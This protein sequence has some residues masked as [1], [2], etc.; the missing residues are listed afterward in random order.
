[1]QLLGCAHHWLHWALQVL[2]GSPTSRH[3]PADLAA[4]LVGQLLQQVVLGCCCC[5][6]QANQRDPPHAVL[7][8]L[9]LLAQLMHCLVYGYR[10]ALLLLMVRALTRCWR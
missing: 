7:L 1:M 5:C 2:N 4:V 3:G 8:Q 6:L 10:P 9:L